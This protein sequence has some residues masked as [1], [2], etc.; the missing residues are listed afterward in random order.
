[1][2]TA[3][4]EE[5]I[6]VAP[7]YLNRGL[8]QSIR[9]TIEDIYGGKCTSIGYID[10]DSIR[11]VSHSPGDVSGSYFTG[12]VHYRVLFEAV[13]HNPPEGS[14]IEGEVVGVN[15]YGILAKSGPIDIIVPRELHTDQSPFE[16][17][18]LGD[19]IEV[20][21]LRKQLFYDE[22]RINVMASFASENGT[23]GP[24]RAPVVLEEGE[25][26]ETDM[27][28]LLEGMPNSAEMKASSQEVEG[29][30]TQEVEGEPEAEEGEEGEVPEA[31]LEE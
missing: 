11:I 14:L 20:R 4:F 28:E 1:M 15:T 2:T 7:R 21:V 9:A 18:S 3:V 27:P 29:E 22:S 19:K 17:V 16:G 6:T 12:E 30:P 8:D 31:E 25:E 26:V 24:P 5:L 23:G 13:V 10:A